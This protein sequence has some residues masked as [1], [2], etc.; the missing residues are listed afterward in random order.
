MGLEGRLGRRDGVSI[1]SLLDALNSGEARGF[2]FHSDG[3]VVPLA[4]PGG[5]WE[6]RG[7]GWV[8]A[9]GALFP[10]VLGT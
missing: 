3:S 10:K 8:K 1:P 9:E 4:R 7:P 6:P 5:L 2:Q